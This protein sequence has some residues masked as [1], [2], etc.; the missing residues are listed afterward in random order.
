MIAR[1]ALAADQGVGLAHAA[2]PAGAAVGVP[3]PANG[4]SA[5]TRR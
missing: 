4:R 5:P 3:V 1:L 2:R